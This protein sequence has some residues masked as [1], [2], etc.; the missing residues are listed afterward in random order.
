M[1]V[2]PRLQ[3]FCMFP[4]Q[5]PSSHPPP[6]PLQIN[7]NEINKLSRQR[8]SLPPQ[9]PPFPSPQPAPP[10]PPTAST[11]PRSSSTLFPAASALLASVSMC[12]LVDAAP[13]ATPLPTAISTMKSWIMSRRN[14]ARWAVRLGF[15]VISQLSRWVILC[16][17]DLLSMFV[18]NIL[19]LM[20]ALQ[21]S[22]RS[23]NIELWS[24]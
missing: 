2:S 6:N 23:C 17:S 21:V 22:T 18:G 11:L 1:F 10:P 15:W 16:M 4:F 24:R 8:P 5:L 20:F 13:I 14:Q 9:H 7:N 3:C 19:K 12:F